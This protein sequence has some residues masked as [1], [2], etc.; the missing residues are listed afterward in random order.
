MQEHVIRLVRLFLAPNLGQSTSSPRLG[1]SR[2]HYSIDDSSPVTVSAQQYRPSVLPR[3][4][5]RKNKTLNIVGQTKLRINTVE[6]T[7]RAPAIRPYPCIVCTLEE[8]ADLCATSAG[9]PPP[10]TPARPR[11]GAVFDSSCCWRRK[12]ASSLIRTVRIDDQRCLM[13]GTMRASGCP[14]PV[15]PPAARLTRS[16]LD[17]TAYPSCV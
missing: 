4:R 9:N 16:R 12:A 5:K 13:P 3:P 2:R 8:G 14:L 15:G 10:G 17:M 11:P 1:Y 7:L 6:A